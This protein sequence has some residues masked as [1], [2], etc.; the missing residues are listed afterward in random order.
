MAGFPLATLD[1][2]GERLGR[3]TRPID[4]HLIHVQN[5]SVRFREQPGFESLR[6]HGLP[7]GE[8]PK[9][10]TIKISYHQI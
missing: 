3:P 8:L 7:D 4:G 1:D 5:P 10:V 2:E 9:S 6:L